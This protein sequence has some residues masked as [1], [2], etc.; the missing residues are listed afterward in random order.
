MPDHRDGPQLVNAL[1]RTVEELPPRQQAV[2]VRLMGGG[3]RGLVDAPDD[4]D[5]DEEVEE[6]RAHLD[7]RLKARQQES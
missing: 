4:D 5:L 7:S 1:F 6:A 2:F 3:P